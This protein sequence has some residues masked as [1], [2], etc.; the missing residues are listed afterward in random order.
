MY[1]PTFD[2]VKEAQKRISPYIHKTPVLTSSF[3]NEF[4]GAELF[5]KCENFQKAGVFK[6][7]GASNAV[8]GLSEERQ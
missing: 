2:D 1:I 5:F 4:S 3:M 7:R 8:F 6:V